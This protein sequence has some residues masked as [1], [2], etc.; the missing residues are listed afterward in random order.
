MAFAGERRR[1]PGSPVPFSAFLPATAANTWLLFE[2]GIDAPAMA[3]D[4][5]RPTTSPWIP[6]PAGELDVADAIVLDRPYGID[7]D[8]LRPIALAIQAGRQLITD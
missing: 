8:R 2:R 4:G 5:G 3:L 6:R 1:Q 7:G